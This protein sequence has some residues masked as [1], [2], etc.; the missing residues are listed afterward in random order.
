M[1]GCSAVEPR[2]D[3][4]RTGHFEACESL[5]RA[6]C[7]DDLLRNDPGGFAQRAR[8]LQS[9]GR[10]DLAETE[11]GRGFERDVLDGE[12]VFFFENGADV[13]A[14]PLLEFQNH[15]ELPQKSLIFKVILT[16]RVRTAGLTVIAPQPK[17]DG[18]K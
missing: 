1:H 7:G 17:I 5:R 3:V 15:V 16:E 18:E 4:A 9:D 12:I 2:I 13:C 14:E 8:Q 11:V 10:G 6:Q